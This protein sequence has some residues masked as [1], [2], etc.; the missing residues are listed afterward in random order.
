M[1]DGLAEAMSAGQRR[2]LIR[3]LLGLGAAES[4][5]PE[6]LLAHASVPA[7]FESKWGQGLWERIAAY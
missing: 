1:P 7:K 5:A 3:F 4:V 6:K 2:D